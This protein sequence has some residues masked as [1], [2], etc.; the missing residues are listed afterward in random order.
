MSRSIV[1]CAALCAGMFSRGVTSVAAP[2]TAKSPAPVE[3]L[4]PAALEALV[5]GVALYP[6]PLVEQIL[7][8]AQNP[9]AVHQA[10]EA[11]RGELPAEVAALAAESGNAGVDYLKQ[12]PEVLAQLDEQLALTARLGV[13]YRTQPQDVWNAIASVRA[14]YEAALAEQAATDDAAA[15]ST[16][17]SSGGAYPVYGGWVA[18]SLLAAG[19]IHEL[20]EYRYDQYMN[21]GA[22]TTTTTY[23]GPNG[24][25]ATVT[26]TGN[27]FS[28]QNGATTAQGGAGTA[29]VTGPNGQTATVTGGGVGGQTTVG[30][31]TYFGATGGGT[32]TGPQGESVSAAGGVKGSATQTENGAQVQTQASG[33]YS[34]SSGASGA[35]TRSGSTNVTQNADG[36]TSW[37]HTASGQAS[38][39]NGS[40]NYQHTGSGTATGDGTGNYQGSTTVNANGNSV[41]TETTAGN[42]EAS[43]TVTN[44][45]TG[46]SSTYTAGDG[47]IENAP[48]S[49]GD[50]SR[51][52]PA[53]GGEAARTQQSTGTRDWSQ[54]SRDQISQASQAMKQSWGQLGSQVRGGSQANAATQRVQ[55]AA[56]QQGKAAAQQGKAAANNLKNRT[57]PSGARTGANK[58]SQFS[59]GQR[60]QRGSQSR[61][62]GGRGGRGG[63]R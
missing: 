10:A 37:N 25:T 57:A 21:S 13:A 40:G 24:E 19:A 36:S 7:A 51:T 39:T 54:M 4:S 46:A 62:S 16:G 58:K 56:A 41:S 52:Q 50:A 42:G 12:Y 28:Y 20:N 14:A 38:G 31:T 61:P 43:T 35:G 55:G 2:P 26:S 34:T 29:T 60:S 45:N 33:A 3:A 30:D 48:A 32:A 44:N 63:R 23:V 59:S 27:G 49:T 1:F 5:S 6:D 22:N 11:Q 15:A 47:Q 8:A 9:L 18:R 17:S 53:G